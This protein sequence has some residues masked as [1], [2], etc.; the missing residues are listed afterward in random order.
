[1]S[2]VLIVE[3]VVRLVKFV[4]KTEYNIEVLLNS[5]VVTG[6]H[7]MFTKGNSSYVLMF[8]PVGDDGL[9]KTE[10]RNEGKN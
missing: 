6:F 1:M 7:V 9:L 5:N 2:L 10:S 4:T 8:K 3:M